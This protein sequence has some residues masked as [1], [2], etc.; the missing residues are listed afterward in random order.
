MDVGRV[1]EVYAPAPTRAAGEVGSGYRLTEQLVLTAAHVVTGLP[2]AA[3]EAPVLDTLVPAAVCQARPIGQAD[4][5]PAVVVWRNEAA[6]VAVLRLAATAP[7]VPPASPAPRWGRMEGTEP[8]AVSAVGFPWAQER[9]NRVRDTEHLYGFLA[10]AAQLK[11]GQLAVTVL[12]SPPTERTSG[13]PWAGMSG[14]ALFAGPFLIGVVVVDPGRFGTDR[15]V[16]APVAPPL[17]DPALTALLG[18]SAAIVTPVGPRLRLALTADTSLAVMP[19]YR[20]PTAWLGKRQPARFL[21]PEYGI[22]PFLGREQELQTLQAWCLDGASRPL[23]L[24][25]GSGGAGKSR[26][27]AELCVR[28]AGHGWQAGVADPDTP[29]G[30]AELTLDRATLLVVDDADLHGRLLEALVR[31]LGYW[32]PDAP[33]VRLLLLARH[34]AGW[35]AILNQRTDHLTDDLA[36]ESLALKEGGLPDDER[37]THHLQA[38]TAF[39][40][41][42]PNP[43]DA[44]ERTAPDLTDAA[45]ANPLLVH[46]AALLAAASAEVPTTGSAVRERVLDAV[47]DRERARW[48][49]TFPSDVPTGGETT[50]QQVI[51]TATLLAPPD[52]AATTALLTLIGDFSDAAAGAR[53]AVATWLHELYPGAGPPWISPLRPDLLTEQLLTTCPGLAELVLTG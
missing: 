24:L 16:A 53:A 14:A 12:T 19:P 46:M 47:L 30:R 49:E 1:I 27:A 43:A 13:S 15:V 6:D 51:A 44:A 18:T 25:L 33:P 29:G 26:L 11:S 20:P 36:E 48:P 17:A 21:L 10:P 8:I 32:P 4:W 7:G 41:H 50:R 35:W 37:A 45:F 28:M 2:V 5:V 38:L 40:Q 34:T 3:P 22:V 31:V 39:T 42:L 23:R 9:P 52:E